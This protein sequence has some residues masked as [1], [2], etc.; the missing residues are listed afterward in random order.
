MTDQASGDNEVEAEAA[1]DEAEQRAFDAGPAGLERSEEAAD[2]SEVEAAFKAHVDGLGLRF[3]TFREFLFLGGTHSTPGSRCFG[4][5]ALP[6]KALW[7]NLDA[8]ARALDELRSR[9]NAPIR[10]NSIYRNEAYNRCLS[11]TA[12]ESQHKQMRAIDFT[13]A[14]GRGPGHWS[15]VLIRMRDVEGVFSGGIGIYNTFVHVDTRGHRAD[16]DMRH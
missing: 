15:D 10:L 6:A 2:A 9:L 11:G 13:A 8:T 14:D 1:A 5:N 16:W 3:F 7:R 4:L 12:S